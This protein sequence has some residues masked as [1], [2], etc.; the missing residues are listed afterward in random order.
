MII[1]NSKAPRRKEICHMYVHKHS[2]VP[3]FVH[4]KKSDPLHSTMKL[5]LTSQ[6]LNLVTNS[7]LESHTVVTTGEIGLFRWTALSNAL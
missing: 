2:T 4:E 7:V 6:N 5:S 1:S 3:F